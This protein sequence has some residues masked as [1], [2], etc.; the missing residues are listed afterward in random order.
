MV[1]EVENSMIIEE[2][3]HSDKGDTF[4]V[5]VGEDA[6]QFHA[7]ETIF[8]GMRVKSDQVNVKLNESLHE[9]VMEAI[10]IKGGGRITVEG[11]VHGD[12][13]VD[14]PAAD[15][16][17]RGNVHG[18]ITVK[19]GRR[20]KCR[21]SIHGNVRI[22]NATTKVGLG[23][24]YDDLYAEESG[25]VY[26]DR[27]F[28]DKNVKERTPRQKGTGVDESSE[29]KSKSKEHSNSI[30]NEDFSDI[31]SDKLV[32]WIASS[33]ADVQSS[34]RD[35]WLTDRAY[36]SIDIPKVLA[37][38]DTFQKAERLNNHN[39]TVN[40]TD[41]QIKEI[42]NADQLTKTG[43][44]ETIREIIEHLADE[45]Y[46]ELHEATV[47]FENSRGNSENHG[48]KKSSFKDT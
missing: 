14:H 10:Q 40:F 1:L 34:V 7:S 17:V 6:D 25:N 27:V 31:E 35:I 13:A 9:G 28:G 32:V 23:T 36:E 29:I 5:E 37:E 46:D 45:S 21:Q 48:D 16:D 20:V 38:I 44:K 47:G 24:V 2:S 11:D 30:Y 33:I 15:L 41:K 22:K 19:E 43:S 18:D 3:I 42:K 4:A 8:G 12:I 39:S 26:Y